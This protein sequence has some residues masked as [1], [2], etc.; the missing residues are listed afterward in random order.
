MLIQLTGL[1]GS[2]KTT[3]ANLVKN[4]L[5]IKGI[6]VDILD[7]DLYRTT[8]CKDLGYSK[9][10]R[11]ENISRLA[12]IASSLD[13]QNKVVIIAAINPYQQMRNL[14]TD[15]YGSKTVWIK[16]PLHILIQRDTKGYYKKAMLP[17]DHPEKIFGFTGINDPFETPVN[18][19][20]IIETETNTSSVA[21]E[22]L[23]RFIMQFLK[24]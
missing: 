23:I 17:D 5:E 19:D 8:V 20:L 1:S 18:A 13:Q 9:K 21:S 10:D 11:N 14:L 24:S 7:A 3:I 4:K 15:R 16:C 22:E 6:A 2:G 12:S